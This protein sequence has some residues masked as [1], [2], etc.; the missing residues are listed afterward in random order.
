[1]LELCS[2]TPHRFHI[3]VMGTGFTIDTPLRVARFGISSVVS[4]VDDVLI[5]Q[6]RHRLS[7]MLGR[8]CAEID[9]QDI[10]CRE[11]RIRAYLDLLHDEVQRQV[12]RMRHGAFERG[13]EL[14][15]YFEMLPPSPARSLYDRMLHSVDEEHRAQLQ[16]KLRRLVHPGSIDVN[17]MTKLDRPHL[18]GGKPVGPRFSDA[19]TALRGF[20]R[21]KLHSSVILSAGMNRGLFAQLTE[22][23]DFYPSA[24]GELRK[25]II[26]KVSD[27]RSAMIQGRMLAKKGLWVSE[28]RIES[29]LNCGGHA[30]GGGGRLLGPILEEFREQKGRFVA[31]LHDVH[32]AALESLGRAP[33]DAPL[34]VR[35]TVQGGIGT[36]DE[37]RMLLE[38]YGVDGTGWGSPFLFCPEAVNIDDEHLQQ[39]CDAGEKDVELSRNSPL[40]V[41][42]WNLRTS[43]SERLRKQRIEEGQPGSACPKGYLISNT[44]FSERAICTASRRYQRQKLQELASSSMDQ[45][46]LEDERDL[47][48]SKACICQDLAGS[49]NRNHELGGEIATTVCC[50][51]NSVYYQKRSTLREM[52]DHIYGRTQLALASNRPH[53]FLKELGIHVDRL[54]EATTRR[55]LGLTTDS[56]ASLR[57]CK[58]NL[59][60][61]IAHYREKAGII[62]QEKAA[63]FQARLEAAR[64]E[65]ESLLPDEEEAA[66]EQVV[67]AD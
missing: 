11:R 13:S 34:P 38:T 32:D 42:F 7:D 47:T 49:A 22:F 61:G 12:E 29:G 43:A 63:S 67:R 41:P 8:E 4:L 9:R 27:L 55:A 39:L 10:E 18:R 23:E 31:K 50:G 21:S 46:R 30:F 52:V 33:L 25:K 37:E 16:E 40:G 15:K 44:E 24:T 64:Q 59:L 60:A 17:I 53:M 58:S 1:M 19:L 45:E 14:C 51:P 66:S 65:I 2:A 6:M 3:P 28:Y 57:E 35:V 62:A 26:L 54:R 56:T 48:L 36:S 5:E 20:A